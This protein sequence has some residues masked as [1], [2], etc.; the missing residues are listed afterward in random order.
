MAVHNLDKDQTA[1]VPNGPTV[2]CKGGRASFVS[3]TDGAGIR[4]IQNGEE[5]VQNWNGDLTAVALVDNT[6]IVVE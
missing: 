3:V 4:S 1:S 6:V 2:A 5:F